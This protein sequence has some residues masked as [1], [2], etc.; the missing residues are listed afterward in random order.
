MMI[1]QALATPMRSADLHATAAA[2]YAAG[3]D[4]GKAQAQRVAARA[5]NPKLETS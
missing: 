3:G 4:E 1:E 5:I 2:V